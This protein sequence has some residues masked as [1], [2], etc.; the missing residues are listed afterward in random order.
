MGTLGTNERLK[1]DGGAL[2]KLLEE[3]RKEGADKDPR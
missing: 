1:G 3:D 2:I